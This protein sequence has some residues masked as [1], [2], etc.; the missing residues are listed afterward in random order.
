M[1]ETLYRQLIDALLHLASSIR[2]DIV[3]AV[4]YLYHFLQRPTTQIW[5]AIKP[6]LRNLKQCPDL[7][8][9][10]QSG[11]AEKIEADFNAF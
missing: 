11:E 2:L 4:H 1:D 8:L 7:G 5:K 9:S 3:Y 6:V 10:F